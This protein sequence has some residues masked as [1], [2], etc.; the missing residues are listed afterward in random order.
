MTE[1]VAINSQLLP[2]LKFTSLSSA[3]PTVRRISLEAR[4]PF[5]PE[6]YYVSIASQLH[7]SRNEK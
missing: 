6:N 5:M 4:K 3:S 7:L 2:Y 1:S